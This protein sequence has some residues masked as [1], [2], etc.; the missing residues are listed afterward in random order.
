MQTFQDNRES[1]LQQ[2]NTVNTDSNALAVMFAVVT[3]DIL[4]FSLLLPVLPYYAAEFGAT[5]SVVGLLGG[6]YAL[7]QL[8]GAPV[9]ARL[10]DYYGRKPMLML[11]IAGSIIGF[12]MLGT[13]THLWMFFVSRIVAGLVAANVPIAQAYIS[14]VSTIEE[15]SRSLGV[16]GAAFGVG[17]T[18][19]PVL[20]GLLA[21]SLGYAFVAF[22]S[23][24]C[25]VANLLVVAVLVRESLPVQRR[26]QQYLH[27]PS[28]AL[29]QRWTALQTLLQRPVIRQLLVFWSVFSLALAVFQ[30]NIALFNQY[31]LHLTARQTGM[32]FATIGVCVSLTQGIALR[33]LAARYS[34]VQ[35]V[36]IALPVFT[37]SLALWAFTN[38]LPMLY[39]VT[40]PFCVGGSVLITITN[41]ILT[42]Y[43]SAEE[44]GGMMGIAAAIDN[45]TRVIGS[46]VG[47]VLIQH[48][49][50]FAPGALAAVSMLVLTYVFISHIQP[51]LET[52]PTPDVV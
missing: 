16:I 45:A 40:V 41:S 50:G 47:G 46:L 5:P 20:G 30:Q 42:K 19:G 1:N 4:G 43:V 49:G 13:A 7:C 27:N 18:I 52:T 32:V 48:L 23:A 36:L 10:S 6:V 21:K 25:A 38:S 11:D 15:R 44:T 22:A 37:G 29:R 35:L 51:T 14:D 39:A 8:I 33:L 28:S 12:L 24:C 17:F 31:H 26:Q 2:H 3:L 34:D 9:M